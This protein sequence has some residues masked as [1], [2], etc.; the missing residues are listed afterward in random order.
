MPTVQWSHPARA[1]VDRCPPTMAGLWSASF[2]AQHVALTLAVSSSVL[3]TVD[4]TEIAM[5]LGDAVESLEMARPWLIDGPIVKLGLAS[6]IIDFAG[7]T[8][9]LAELIVACVELAAATLSNRDE[10]LTPGEVLAVSRCVG[11]LSDAH[12]R[13]TGRLP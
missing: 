13:A 3:P 10:S 11:L 9:E 4:F 12:V 5:D 2:T 6:P 7:P 8:R 1:L